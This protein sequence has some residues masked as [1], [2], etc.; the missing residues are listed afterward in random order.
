MLRFF[1]T[2]LVLLGVLFTVELLNPVQ[3]HV[4]IPF[5][6]ILARISAEIM[7]FFDSD[8]TSS[9]IIIRSLSSG[10]S[11]EIRAGCNGVEAVIILFAAV[12]AFPAPWKHKIAGFI[13]GFFAI[14][15]LH[16]VC[17]DLRASAATCSTIKQQQNFYITVRG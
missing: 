1:I 13:A 17:L 15:A 8:V 11:V 9:G 12:F 14:Q 7:Q 16:G 4:V 2:F 3:E 10:F 5:T 6:G